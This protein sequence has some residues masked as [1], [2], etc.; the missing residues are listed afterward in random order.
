[1]AATDVE[2]GGGDVER[3]SPVMAQE[4]VENVDHAVL[5]GVDD[6][7]DAGHKVASIRAREMGII[8]S[9]FAT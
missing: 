5:L 7:W 6:E 8:L 3:V 2:V 4:G 9:D 1:M